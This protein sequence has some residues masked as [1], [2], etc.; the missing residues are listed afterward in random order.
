MHSCIHCILYTY[1]F[2]YCFECDFFPQK[3][4]I[5][6]VH[7]CNRSP[8]YDSQC[9]FVLWM[10][11]AHSGHRGLHKLFFRKCISTSQRTVINRASLEDLRTVHISAL[12]MVYNVEP[13][14]EKTKRMR[15]NIIYN[16]VACAF[17]NTINWSNKIEA[18]WLWD[19][20]IINNRNNSST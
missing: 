3:C 7:R 11:G 8:M 6:C 13:K 10:P 18:I 17:S 20:I 14:N 4:V 1:G 2:C 19:I 16:N 5:F 12:W 9:V 15:F